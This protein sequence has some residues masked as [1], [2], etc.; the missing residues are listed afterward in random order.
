LAGEFRSGTAKR[1]IQE[2]AVQHRVQLDA[3]W[4]NM[5]AGRALDR[6]ELLE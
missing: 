6:I 1:L 5:E 3:N 4:A 2:W